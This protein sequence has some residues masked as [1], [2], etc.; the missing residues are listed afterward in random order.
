MGPVW[1]PGR[2]VF[3][4]RGSYMKYLT[5]SVNADILIGRS[6]YSQSD[7]ETTLTT[8]PASFSFHSCIFLLCNKQHQDNMSVRRIPPL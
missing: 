7:D 4:W 6:F 2:L 1:K 5:I 8:D 3:S